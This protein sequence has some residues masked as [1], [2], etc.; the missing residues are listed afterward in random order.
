[1]YPGGCDMPPR[2]HTI[3][4]NPASSK[5]IVRGIVLTY[6]TSVRKNTKIWFIRSFRLS[7]KGFL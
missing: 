4:N 7:D 1:G 5:V 2:L 3:W 6:V